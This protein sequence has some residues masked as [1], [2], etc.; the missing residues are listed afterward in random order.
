MAFSFHC[1]ICESQ[2]IKHKISTLQTNFNKIRWTF[3]CKVPCHLLLTFNVLLKLITFK[4][5]AS[6]KICQPS[7]WWWWVVLLWYR[8]RMVVAATCGRR[9]LGA[10]QTVIQ[11]SPP[12]TAPLM[13][14]R[15]FYPLFLDADNSSERNEQLELARIS[16]FWF[17]ALS[18]E[19]KLFLIFLES[20]SSNFDKVS[21]RLELEL[22]LWNNF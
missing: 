17:R 8:G 14:T 3:C 21:S 10:Q 1:Y 22:K 18:F 20:S 15:L 11:L 16:G 7:V 2:C 9:F 5:S 6:K 4:M 19:L 12:D 13:E